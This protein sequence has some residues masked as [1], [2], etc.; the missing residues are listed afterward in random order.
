MLDVI[1]NFKQY[2]ED[3]CR[4]PVNRVREHMIR[5]PQIMDNLQLRSIRDLGPQQV[6]R[7]W[8][9]SRWKPIQKG[10]SISE[11]AESGY[12]TVLKMFL[13]Y[14]EDHEYPVASGLADIIRI[15]APQMSEVREMDLAERQ[16]LHAY[17]A[18]PTDKVQVLRD[19]MLV[20]LLWATKNCLDDVL[21]LC[22]SGSG[23]LEPGKD[24]NRAGHFLFR[25]GCV[26]LVASVKRGEVV[27][28]VLPEEIIHA[29]QDYLTN[30]ASQ[31]RR[32]F[33]SLRG[34]VSRKIMT[35]RAAMTAIHKLVLGAGIQVPASSVEQLLVNSA[36][37]NRQMENHLAQTSAR[38]IV[39]MGDDSVEQDELR[40]WMLPQVA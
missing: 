10:I 36:Y 26:S 30:R 1:H 5:M 21:Q 19:R 37:D 7:E 24:S 9:H 28:R 13:T 34:K 3:D 2:L 40:N 15:P 35:K 39:L 4:L 8:R 29:L 17:L 14:L 12:L 32:L 33:L 6:N 20:L 23:K 31:D 27:E 25:D 18:Q 38:E 16:Q 11:T 22:V